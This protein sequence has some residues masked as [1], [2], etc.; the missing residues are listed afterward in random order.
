[1]KEPFAYTIHLSGQVAEAEIA[2]SPIHARVTHPAP[3]ATSLE[4]VTDQ[5][6]LL[7]LLAYLHGIGLTITKVELRS[8]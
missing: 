6:G 2:L 4:V 5:S 7:G 8:L 3:S 1:M